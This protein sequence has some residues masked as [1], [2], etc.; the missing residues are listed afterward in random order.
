MKNISKLIVYNSDGVILGQVVHGDSSHGNIEFA[1]VKAA[2]TYAKQ[3]KLRV[4]RI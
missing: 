2:K 4:V 3:N 1:T